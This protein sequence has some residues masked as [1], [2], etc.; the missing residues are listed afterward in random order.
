MKIFLIGKKYVG[1]SIDLDA[2]LRGHAVDLEKNR[3]KNKHLQNS[4]NKYKKEGFIFYII[5]LCFSDKLNERE[6]YWIKKFKSYCS[7]CGYNISYGGNAPMKGRKASQ[8]TRDRMSEAKKGWIPSQKLIDIN[9]ERMLSDK[10]PTRGKKLTDEEKK[11]ISI[12]LTGKHPSIETK[13]KMGKKSSGKNI[14][15]IHL[16]FL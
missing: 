14:I 1:Q 15:K 5:E 4:Y 9:R 2:R 6:I 16:V 8:E 13:K 10:H 7:D 12:K 11:N 3:H